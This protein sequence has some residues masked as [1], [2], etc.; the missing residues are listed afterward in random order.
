MI[1]N[2]ALLIACASLGTGTTANAKSGKNASDG[3]GSFFCIKYVN[4]VPVYVP[5]K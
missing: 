3:W 2:I 5:C 4:G 1:K